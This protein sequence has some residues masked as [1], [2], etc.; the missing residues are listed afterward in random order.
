M[1]ISEVTH[2]CST[3]NAF[4][5][6]ALM[7][8]SQI[9]Y[10]QIG[11]LRKT[12]N[13]LKKYHDSA[14]WYQLRPAR[15]HKTSCLSEPGLVST[16]TSIPNSCIINEIDTFSKVAFYPP[17]SSHFSALVF[18]WTWAGLNWHLKAESFYFHGN[19]RICEGR[20]LVHCKIYLFSGP[21]KWPKRASRNYRQIALT[22][23]YALKQRS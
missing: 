21:P 10:G 6:L 2:F 23:E 11:D 22:H 3:S 18:E 13:F 16:G 7:G 4:C 1:S 20:L 5:L 17:N 19:R 15:V 12:I 8:S 9:W 14:L